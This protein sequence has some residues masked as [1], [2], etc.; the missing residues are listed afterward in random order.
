MWESDQPHGGAAAKELLSEFKKICGHHLGLQM[1]GAASGED[2]AQCRGSRDCRA[3][4]MCGAPRENSRAR[5]W[6]APITD[7]R[8]VTACRSTMQSDTRT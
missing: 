8:M 7:T 3:L 4:A 6:R 1:D 5:I 2:L